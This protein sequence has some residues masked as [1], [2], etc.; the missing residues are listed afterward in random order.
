[1][2]KQIEDIINTIEKAIYKECVEIQPIPDGDMCIRASCA[3]CKIARQLIAEGYRKQEWI[4][5]KYRL[6]GDGEERVMV[7][8][9]TE[10]NIGR[11]KIDTDRYLD[12]RWVRW[13]DSVTHWM[14]LPD[15][16]KGGDN[17]A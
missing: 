14:P 3:V 13:G 5:V 8:L 15:A 7:A 4:S 10:D 6:P 9:N 12:G 16:P 2:N 17:D 1:M 11:N